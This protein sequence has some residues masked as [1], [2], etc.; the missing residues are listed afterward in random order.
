MPYKWTNQACEKSGLVS[1]Q[2]A[3]GGLPCSAFSAAGCGVLTY[4]SPQTLVRPWSGP[5][6]LIYELETWIA[7]C[8]FFVAGCGL[9]LPGVAM[10]KTGVAGYEL[11]DAWYCTTYLVTGRTWFDNSHNL[12]LLDFTILIDDIS[13]SGIS[14]YWQDNASYW[15]EINFRFINSQD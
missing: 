15:F 10:A 1:I 6:L 13:N 8:G 9:R 11:W 14:A 2:S 5:K 12:D 3:F 7:G 4:A